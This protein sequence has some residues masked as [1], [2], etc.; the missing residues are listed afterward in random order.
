MKTVQV[1]AECGINTVIE[2]LFHVLILKPDFCPSVGHRIV[3]SFAL[4]MSRKFTCTGW[5]W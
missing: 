4:G 2:L 3:S 1:R 5:R